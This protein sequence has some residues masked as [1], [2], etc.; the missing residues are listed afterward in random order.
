MME[1]QRIFWWRRKNAE[2]DEP[3]VEEL[4]RVGTIATIKQVMNLP[5]TASRAGRG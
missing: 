2:V 3:T 4:C 1:N 5:A